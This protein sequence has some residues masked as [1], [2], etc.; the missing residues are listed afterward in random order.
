MSQYARSTWPVCKWLDSV[1]SRP[2]LREMLLRQLIL[3]QQQWRSEKVEHPK[4]NNASTT[5][6]L[7]STAFRQCVQLLVTSETLLCTPHIRSSSL[8]H[9]HALLTVLT[10]GVDACAPH[11]QRNGGKLLRKERVAVVGCSEKESFKMTMMEPAK[12]RGI[13]FLKAELTASVRTYLVTSIFLRLVAFGACKT[14]DY[15]KFMNFV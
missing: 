10:G 7:H 13:R 15:E 9:I 4:A 2:V 5:Y 14:Y 6:Y 8:F 3:P 11:V 1:L 12:G